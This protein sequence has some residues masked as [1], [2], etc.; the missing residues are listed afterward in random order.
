MPTSYC[1]SGREGKHARASRMETEFSVGCVSWPLL[2]MM[3]MMMMM[4]I[5]HDSQQS[6]RVSL[7]LPN[8]ASK[9]ML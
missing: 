8:G 9:E 6:V 7:F 5:I 3:M 2:M 4:I 1:T